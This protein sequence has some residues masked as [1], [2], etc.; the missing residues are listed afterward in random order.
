MLSEREIAISARGLGKTYR[1]GAGNDRAT[2]LGEAVSRIAAPSKKRAAFREF[3]A[4]EDVSFDIQEGE[5]F[6]IIGRNGAGKSTLLKI[7]SRI[8][9]PSRG[10]VEIYGR[11]GSLLEVGTGF[12]PELTG[13]ENIYLNGAMLGMTRREIRGKFE[14]IVEFAGTGDFLDTPVKRYS[15]GMYVRLAFAVAACLEP[16]ILLVDEV[17]AV[18]DAQFQ[19]KCL[20]KMREVS[21]SHG[22]TVLLVSHNMGAVTALTNRAIYLESGRVAAIGA[23]AEVVRKYLACQAQAPEEW[24]AKRTTDHPVQILKT[25]ML[26]PDEIVGNEFEASEKFTVEMTYEVRRAARNTLIEFFILTADGVHLVTCGDH[27]T[28]PERYALREPGIYTTR[29][30]LP[31]NFLNVG[32]YILRINSGT[33][34]ATYDHEDAIWF[35]IA[36]SHQLTSRHN[37]RGLVLPMLPWTTEARR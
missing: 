26:G 14:T 3:A 36:E 13:R 20:G 32:T 10:R 22:R 17:L 21:Q 25:R 34:H 1:I 12:H 27:D 18:G 4:L 31:G 7:L 8:A 35:R 9:R 16:D 6:G 23:T 30:T 11:V 15:S 29:V 19:M 2:T 5:V 24:T 28:A 33:H 37:R